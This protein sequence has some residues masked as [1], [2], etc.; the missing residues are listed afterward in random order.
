M[1]LRPYQIECVDAIMSHL[2]NDDGNPLAEMATGTGKSLVIAA[3]TKRL[4]EE[5]SARVLMLVHVREL[6]AQNTAE[7]LR[8]WPAAP[9]GINS[10]GLGRRDR[11]SQ[12]LFASIQSVARED[13]YSLG[14][15]HVILVDEAHL[16]PRSGD[17]QYRTLIGKLRAAFP[18]LRIIGFT[19]TGYRLD[20]GRLDQGDDALFDKTVYTYD[21][22][23]GVEDGFLAP[24]VSRATGQ[25]ID[26][27]SVTRRGGEFVTGSLEAAANKD[28]ITQAACSEI[29]ERGADRRSWLIF[30][31]GVVHA[32][33]VRDVM[34]A[35]GVS[36]E[37]VTGETPKADRDSIFAAFKA[38][39]IRALAGCQVFTTGFNAP[40]VDLIAMLRPTLSTSLYVQMLGRG[41]RLAGGKS[42]CLVLDFAG[43]VIRHGPVD[44]VNVRSNRP[45]ASD[46]K[47][48]VDSVQAKACPTCEALVSTRVY[49]CPYCGHEWPK[50][51]EPKHSAQA[52]REA[53]VMSREVVARWLNVRDAH[54]RTHVKDERVSLR[55]DYEIG[56]SVYSEWVTL[57][58]DGFAGAKGAKWWRTIIGTD[59]PETC[60]RATGAFVQEARILSIMVARDGKY[61][62]VTNWRVMR[63]DGRVVEI[64]SK[65]NVRPS[66][67]EI[68][69][70]S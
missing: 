66:P 68:A 24:L 65:F 12:I 14:E 3:L 48:T 2:D 28:P 36:C 64:D 26:V 45:G 7:L 56:A 37:T 52:D 39:R 42:D 55:I 43:N 15:R 46:G 70:A 41:T 53:A 51:Q 9:V 5:C 61:W 60:I 54:A 35:R 29:I 69:R 67:L 18:D 4:V 17:G 49:T 23:Q 21:I 11:R 10:A 6:V 30:C 32:E 8:A 33:A 58:H 31:T 1:I 19:A 40:S 38:G 27:S 13:A 22:A 47:V 16:L 59:V 25:V 50:P 57:E 20:S 62:R 34:R 63:A 44:A